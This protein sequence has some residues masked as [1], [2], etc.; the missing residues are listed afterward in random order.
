[1]RRGQ[2]IIPDFCPTMAAL[3]ATLCNQCRGSGSGSTGSI[4]FWASWIRIRILLTLSKYH[5][6]NLDFY[7]FVTSF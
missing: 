4:C 7:C 3:V 6:K 1:M 2:V 5:K